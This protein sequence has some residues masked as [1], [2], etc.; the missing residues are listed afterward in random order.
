MLVFRTESEKKDI[1]WSFIDRFYQTA[2]SS[3]SK[4]Q[5]SLLFWSRHLCSVRRRR[6]EIA[7]TK[8]E[9]TDLGC[10]KTFLLRRVRWRQI[11]GCREDQK[12]HKDRKE[13]PEWRCFSGRWVD[14]PHQSFPLLL[15]PCRDDLWLGLVP[16]CEGEKPSRTLPQNGLS[17]CNG[18]H[19]FVRLV[20]SPG[21]THSHS[22]LYQP[23]A[24]TYTRTVSTHARTHAP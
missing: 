20:F 8:C 16:L 22:H 11:D 12:E 18:N 24:R 1:V 5:P 6:R 13:R 19:S 14:I 7:T 17:L 2:F 3:C 15:F 21:H 9:R 10:S 23:P 4:F